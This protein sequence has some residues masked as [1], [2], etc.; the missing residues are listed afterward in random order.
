[1]ANTNTAG[2]GLIPAGTLGSTPSTQGQGKYFIEA[3]YNADLFQG[4][5]VR[6][7]NGYVISAQASITTST[8]GVLNGIF[9]NAAT[10]KKPTWANWYNQPITPANSEN[11]TAFVLDNPFQLYVGS[12]AAAILQA[13]FFET[14]GLTVTAAGSETSGQSSSELIGTAA[15]TANAWRV[16]RTAEDPENEDITSTNCSVVCVQNLNQ[17]NSGGLTSAS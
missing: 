3:A 1:M 7:V 9:Y 11:I 10:T 5:S 8:I 12:M 6:I 13:D 15:A 14:Y 16:I 17:I 4:S 2:F